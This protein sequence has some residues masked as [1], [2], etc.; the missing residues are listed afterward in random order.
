[1]NIAE[2]ENGNEHEFPVK[3]LRAMA[4]RILGSRMMDMDSVVASN[5]GH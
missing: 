1:M 4:W 2:R 5:A 3:P